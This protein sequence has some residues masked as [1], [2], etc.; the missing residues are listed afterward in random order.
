[1]NQNPNPLLDLQFYRITAASTALGFGCLFAFLY[2]LRDVA[3][4]VTFG[5][6]I[7][8]VIAFLVGAALGW[9]FWAWVR[10]KVLRAK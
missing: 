3:H 1:M 6:T 10:S 9:G 2:S 7:G 5:F 8:T 4:D